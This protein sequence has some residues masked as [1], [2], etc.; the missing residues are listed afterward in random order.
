MEVSSCNNRHGTVKTPIH[1][2]SRLSFTLYD[3]KEDL[4]ESCAV[5][6]VES[7]TSQTIE[8]L[9]SDLSIFD[10]AQY[11]FDPEDD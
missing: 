4:R 6:K 8:L 9:I 5:D 2:L 11:I 10:V 1:T 3:H 7:F